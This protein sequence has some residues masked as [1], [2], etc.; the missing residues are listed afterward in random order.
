VKSLL[1]IFWL[2]VFTIFFSLNLPLAQANI[3]ISEVYPNPNS[4]ENEW[5]E[6]FNTSEDSISLDNWEFWDQKSQPTLI[7]KFLEN[8]TINKQEYLVIPV[9]NVLNNSGDS[10]LLFDENHILQDSLTYTSSEKNY[11]WAKDEQEP[12]SIYK[13]S[14]TLGEKNS[15]PTPTAIPPTP[16]LFLS[17]TPTS[18]QINNIDIFPSFSEVVA[19]PSNQEKEWLEISNLFSAPI[20]LDGYIIRDA[21]HQI[22]KF[23]E[24]IIN[25]SEYITIEFTNTLNNGGD[26]L[27]LISPQNNIVDTFSYETCSKNMSWSKFDNQ[28]LESSIITKGEININSKNSSETS[29][30]TKQININLKNSE[31]QKKINNTSKE[32]KYPANILSPEI[33]LPDQNLRHLQSI[34]FS[35]PDLIKGAINVIMGSLLLLIPSLVYV[36][37]NKKYF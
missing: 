24:E 7:Y 35:P 16:S 6:L 4:N 36:K 28:W 34:F 18:Q 12:T 13:T 37:K 5:I 25:P 31:E 14:P 27:F 9:N 19:C 8:K 32:F 17:P 22:H 26:S 2:V 29:A 30:T 11:S 20:N 15:I 23:S 33:Q 1:Y 21:T 3:I 10:V